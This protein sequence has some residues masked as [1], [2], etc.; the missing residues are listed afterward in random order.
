MFKSKPFPYLLWVNFTSGQ[1][2]FTFPGKLNLQ[3]KAEGNKFLRRSFMGLN[4]PKTSGP[5]PVH[6]LWNRRGPKFH[7]CSSSITMCW[8]GK[9]CVYSLALRPTIKFDCEKYMKQFSFSNKQHYRKKE[10]LK[11]DGKGTFF[12]Q[13]TTHPWQQKVLYPHHLLWVQLQ[14]WKWLLLF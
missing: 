1:F 7:F 11:K 13:S 4:R 6:G 5:V 12:G 3:V 10:C 14:C 2:G 9:I 8:K